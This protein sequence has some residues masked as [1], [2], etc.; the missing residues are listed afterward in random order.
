MAA[1]D[2]KPLQARREKLCVKFAKKSLRSKHND[3]FTVNRS[4][5]FTRDKR[6]YIDM[7]CNTKILQ[8]SHKLFN[9]IAEHLLV[10]ILHTLVNVLVDNRYSC[11]QRHILSPH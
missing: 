9:K 8:V 10:I 5:Y 3:M 1:L 11:S 6:K 4:Q 7:K 2:L